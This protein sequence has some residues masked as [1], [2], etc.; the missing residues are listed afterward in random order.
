MALLK[1]NEKQI[2]DSGGEGFTHDIAAMFNRIAGR[3]DF[4]NHLLSGGLDIY[5]RRRLVSKVFTPANGPQVVV[6]LAC[7]TMDVLK[8]L[9]KSL[10]AHQLFALDFSLSMLLLGKKKL[11]GLL[12]VIMADAAKLPLKNSSAGALTLSFGLRNIRP[13]AAV[14][15]EALRVLCKN[16]RFCILEFSNGRRRIWGGLYNFCLRKILPLA[17]SIFSKDKLAYK[18]LAES[19]L[20]FPEEQQLTQELLEAGFSKVERFPLSSGIVYLHIAIK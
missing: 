10:P 20:T 16:G 9:H 7:G 13:R 8:N 4:M 2:R 19:I 18:Y 14:Y 17:G 3:Y 5:W 15:A 6:D 1:M 11:S 12:P